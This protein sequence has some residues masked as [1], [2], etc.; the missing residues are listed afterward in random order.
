LRAKVERLKI[1]LQSFQNDEANK[2]KQHIDVREQK[3][4]RLKIQLQSFQND[5]GNKHKKHI[6]SH[7]LQ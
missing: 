1:Q 5:E 4:E 7:G 6:E 2:H 3:L